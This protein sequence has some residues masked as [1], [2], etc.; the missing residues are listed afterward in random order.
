ME[1]SQPNS[2]KPY[3]R[4]RRLRSGVHWQG[5]FKQKRKTNKG[6]KTRAGVFPISLEYLPLYEAVPL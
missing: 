5:A 2:F 4:Q 6:R 1:C 3:M